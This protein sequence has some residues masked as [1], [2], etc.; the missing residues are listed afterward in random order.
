MLLLITAILL[1]P[2]IGNFYTLKWIAVFTVLIGKISLEISKRYIPILGITFFYFALYSLLYGNSFFQGDL[3]QNLVMALSGMGLHSLVTVLLFSGL[4]FFNEIETTA[5]LKFT[6]LIIIPLSF[7]GTHPV[8]NPVMNA[9]LCVITLPFVME[10]NPVCAMAYILMTTIICLLSTGST[11]V[12]AFIAMMTTLFFIKIE[13]HH[14]IMFTFLVGLILVG[15]GGIFMPHLLDTSGRFPMQQMFL[16]HLWHDFNPVI[17][18]GPGSF[19]IWSSHYYKEKLGYT[20]PD[21]WMWAHSDLLQ[22]LFE[23]GVIGL[24]FVTGTVLM[25]I[26]KANDTYKVAIIAYVVTSLNYYPSHWPIH[27]VIG[28]LLISNSLKKGFACKK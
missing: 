11:A 13:T 26:R 9:C 10:L 17:G 18:A 12:A 22:L 25:A 3:K 20:D 15:L 24:F 2:N 4:L 16:S 27:A 7:L 1:L 23:Y 8:S 14:K 6:G 19:P 5:F 28:F 21:L